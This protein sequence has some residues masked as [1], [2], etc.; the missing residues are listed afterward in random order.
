MPVVA[1]GEKMGEALL[2]EE[3]ESG[4]PYVPYMM[5]S[6]NMAMEGNMAEETYGGETS[7]PFRKIKIRF[8]TRA[9]YELQ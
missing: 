5:K 1:V 3:T 7:M 2:I 9:E 4:T 8:E 6:A